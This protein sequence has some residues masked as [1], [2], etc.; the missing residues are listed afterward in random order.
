M[1]RDDT[2]KTAPEERAVARER[3]REERA[4]RDAIPDQLPPLDVGQFEGVAPPTHARV[5]AEQILEVGRYVV[6]GAT[7]KDASIMAG[8]SPRILERHRRDYRREQKG[9]PV[10]LSEWGRACAET[11][12]RAL[13]I[14]RYRWQ[15]LAEIGGKGS[16]SA[17]WMLE[18]RGGGEYRAPA[19]RHEVKRESREVVV[20]ATLDQALESTAH[21]LGLNAE[22][23]RAQGDYWARAM[24]AQQ[25]G[26]A[27]PSP[28]T[29][30]GNQ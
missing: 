23:L 13:S 18:R 17:L 11:Y 27:L 22:E 9:E 12:E 28:Q 16:S 3:R 1:N 4:R 15:L 19:Q 2:P 24:T 21:Q 14:R 30:E 8:V 5:T 25:R 7:L 20:T 10:E 6:S 29:D 26:R